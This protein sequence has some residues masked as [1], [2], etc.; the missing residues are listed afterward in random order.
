MGMYEE[1]DA[2]WANASNE[3]LTQRKEAI[4]DCVRIVEKHIGKLDNT[5]WHPED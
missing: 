1:L 5:T 4:E 2:L 3:M